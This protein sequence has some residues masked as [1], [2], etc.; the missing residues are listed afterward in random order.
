MPMSDLD[1]PL[2]L[3][4]GVRDRFDGQSREH[5][6]AALLAAISFHSG[7]PVNVTVPA[8]AEQDVREMAGVLGL[9]IL[10]CDQSLYKP[11]PAN[12]ISFGFAPTTSVV[13]HLTE[14]NRRTGFAEECD[15]ALALGAIPLATRGAFLHWH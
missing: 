4:N 12:G 14:I 2:V 13:A 7:S 5:V 15:L 8:V 3:K 1:V 10:F 6:V 11:W 9:S